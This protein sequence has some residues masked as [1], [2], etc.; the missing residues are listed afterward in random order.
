MHC[1]AE[2]LSLSHLKPRR[3]ARQPRT[4]KE[5][6]LSHT[7]PPQ[8]P[9][10]SLK[11]RAQSELR[12]FVRVFLYLFCT[13]FGYAIYANLL[14]AGTGNHDI[15]YSFAF[16]EAL[17]GAKLMITA[18][19]L[20]FFRKYED[21]PLIYPT[22]FKSVVFMALMVYA[23]VMEHVVEC[24]VHHHSIIET[25]FETTRLQVILAKNLMIFLGL[26]PFFALREI[27]RVRGNWMVYEM[28]FDPGPEGQRL[29]S[30]HDA[31][32]P[33]AASEVVQG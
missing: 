33:P 27:D 22:L 25:L 5:S 4:E 28:F 10:T 6:P 30:L 12:E 15:A 8:E 11:A 31:P 26:L 14:E 20:R 18:K 17:L 19:H 1:G 13:F 21:R 9:G 2:N 23:S 7:L 3:V 16:I 32:Q 24:L 29:R